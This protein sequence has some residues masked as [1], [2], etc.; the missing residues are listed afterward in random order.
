MLTV[1]LYDN[2]AA[3]RYIRIFQFQIIIPIFHVFKRRYRAVNKTKHIVVYLL[4]E[5]ESSVSADLD[6]KR[7]FWRSDQHDH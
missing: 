3:F 4:Q 7:H 1:L 2:D 6:E 5:R